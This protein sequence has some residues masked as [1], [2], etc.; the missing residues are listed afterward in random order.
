MS[1]PLSVAP[2]T[3]NRPAPARDCVVKSAARVLRILEFFDRRRGAANVHAVAVA[4]GYPASSTGALLRSLVATGYLHYDRTAR[5]YAPTLRVTL[6]GADWV[7][8]RLMGDGP[9]QRLMATL[10]ERSGGTVALIAR[11]GDRAEFIHVVGPRRE[12]LAAGYGRPLVSPCIGHALLAALP[13][14]EVRGLLHRLN[15]IAMDSGAPTLR[16]ADLLGHLA[17]LR[18]T[19]H[20]ELLEEGQRI[21]A[22]P[23]PLHERGGPY[24]MAV[25]VPASDAPSRP[26]ELGALLREEILLHL[27]PVA[28]PSGWPVE[29]MSFVSGRAVL[30]QHQAA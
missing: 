30:H 27:G 13:E 18:R 4:L 17:R 23:L 19:G 14:K 25:L 12:G 24:A 8:P 15:A 11:N 7:A 5:T 16:A 20:A 1:I 2:A 21:A 6:L 22:A 26:G 9:L 3:R 10:A 29:H 28:S